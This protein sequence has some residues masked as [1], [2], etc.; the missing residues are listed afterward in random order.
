[1]SIRFDPCNLRSRKFQTIL[2]EPLGDKLVSNLPG[3]GRQTQEN[4]QKTERIIKAKDLL[5]KFM[6]EFQ[7]NDEEFRLW[8]MNNY[9]L[10]EYRATECCLALMD[11]IEQAKK[12]Q[13][14]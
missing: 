12:N 1:M 7:S 14:F 9:G 8:L 6:F 13:W 3:I 4:L 11:Y 2:S 10:H 5:E